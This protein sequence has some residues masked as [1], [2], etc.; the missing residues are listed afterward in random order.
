[1]F[2]D[3]C[4]SYFYSRPSPLHVY[5]YVSVPAYLGSYLRVVMMEILFVFRTLIVNSRLVMYRTYY[6]VYFKSR[7]VSYNV[8]GQESG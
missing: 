8:P 2:V 5:S 3:V 4:S 6:V 7:R 1:M